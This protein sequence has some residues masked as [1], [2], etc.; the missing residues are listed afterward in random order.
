MSGPT[1]GGADT[2]P[3]ARARD[4]LAAVG[5]VA[6][7][8][9]HRARNRLA[10][11]RGGLEL[12][13][14]GLECNLSQEYRDALLKEFDELVSDLNLGLEMVRCNFDTVGPVSAREV[15]GEAARFFGPGAL[16][17]GIIL[18]VEC[19]HES[20]RI[21]ADRQLLR[22]TLLNLLRNSSQA[23]DGRPG[24]MITVRTTDEDG[25]LR[26]E[27]EDNGPGV[28][29]EIHDR[30]FLGPVTGGHG[31]GL[32]LVLCR[33]AMTL[34]QGSVRYATPKGEPGARFHVRLPLAT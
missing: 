2:E 19:G 10:T 29:A 25:S 32:G 21:L 23:L 30:L 33:D 6:S 20:D 5:F 4:R 27:V 8:I 22:L 14:A 12:V 17:H 7:L 34:M 31:T 3:M 26:V 16:R 9:S 18:A 15:V 13:Q 28:P 24:P 1:P 11:L